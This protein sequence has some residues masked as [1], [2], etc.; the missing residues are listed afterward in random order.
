MDAVRIPH[1]IPEDVRK[2]IIEI[3]ILAKQ[4][5]RKKYNGKHK[6]SKT[7]SSS[8]LDNVATLRKVAEEYVKEHDFSSKKNRLIKNYFHS[9]AGNPLGKTPGDIFNVTVQPFA[10]AHFAVFPPKLVEKP[11]TASC[12]ERI[13]PNCGV[14]WTYETIVE[15]EHDRKNKRKDAKVRLD[16]LERVPNDWKPKQVKGSKWVKNCN[17]D[18]DKY[19]PGIVLDP[20]NGSGTTCLVA[21]KLKRRYIGFDINPEYCKMAKDRIG[22][23]GKL[24]E[25][26]QAKDENMNF[27]E[28]IKGFIKQKKSRKKVIEPE[29]KIEYSDMSWEL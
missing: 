18:T 8:V 13:C 14:P 26:S 24:D 1:N 5:K 2:E 27:S 29:E 3:D 25:W 23:R 12:P 6:D 4:T 21:K 28:P 9:I 17:C 11:I 20:F 16:G 19:A 7:G 22:K 15:V 10:D